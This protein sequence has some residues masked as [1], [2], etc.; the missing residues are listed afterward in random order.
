MRQRPLAAWERR[1]ERLR[2]A[3]RTGTHT[4]EEWEWILAECDYRCVVCGEW[5]VA[6]DH[7]IPLFMGGG[8]T[9]VNLQPLCHSCNSAKRSDTTDYRPLHVLRALDM[10]DPFEGD[11]FDREEARRELLIGYEVDD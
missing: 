1:R 11:E 7:I 5:P 6:K 8:D 3:R 2:N 9:M 4:K 10:P